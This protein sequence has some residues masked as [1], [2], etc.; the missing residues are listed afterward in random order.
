LKSLIATVKARSQEVDYPKITLENLNLQDLVV[1]VTVAASQKLRAVVMMITE[2]YL[3]LRQAEDN[4]EVG[5][6]KWLR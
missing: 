1:V 6:F 3:N 2:T 4:A 5:T